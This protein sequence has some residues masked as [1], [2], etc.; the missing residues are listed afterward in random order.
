MGAAAPPMVR[1]TSA[2]SR[3]RSASDF[4]RQ[5]LHAEGRLQARVYPAAGRHRRRE[6]GIG[7]YVQ[8]DLLDLLGLETVA[9]A[10][11]GVQHQFLV[12]RLGSQHR[13][14]QQRPVAAAEFGARPHRP[15]NVEGHAAERALTTGEAGGDAHRINAR[16]EALEGLDGAGV[17][18]VVAHGPGH[19]LPPGVLCFEDYGTAGYG[20]KSGG[21]RH[22]DHRVGEQRH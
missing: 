1:S 20:A 11:A 18:L 2:P 8:Q 22:P 6:P 9:Q 4:C 19:C 12:A 13:D 10:V 16:R 15:D 21:R 7:R 14:D 5:G 3:S 17:A